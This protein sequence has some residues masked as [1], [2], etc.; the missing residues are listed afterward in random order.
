MARYSGLVHMVDLLPT[1]LSVA[2]FEELTPLGLDGVNQWQAINSLRRLAAPRT[3]FVY[4]ID[5]R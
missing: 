5:D 4:N 2:G 3:G 1:V